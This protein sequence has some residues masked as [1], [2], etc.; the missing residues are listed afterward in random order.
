MKISRN[1]LMEMIRKSV[2]K[3][4]NERDLGTSVGLKRFD[5][6]LDTYNNIKKLLN[7]KASDWDFLHMTDWG[8]VFNNLRDTQRFMLWD[9]GTNEEIKAKCKEFDKNVHEIPYPDMLIASNSSFADKTESIKKSLM[10]AYRVY[11]D[12]IDYLVS[13]HESGELK[14]QDIDAD[15]A[16]FDNRKKKMIDA[17]KLDAYDGM[18]HR[19]LKNGF[20]RDVNYPDPLKRYDIVANP[21]DEDNQL[22]HDYL[23]GNY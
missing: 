6:I 3:V 19:Q 10:C 23:T 1:K 17:S 8:K 11:N 2:Q 4:L 9:C 15:W 14:Q 20:G 18:V 21:N 22:Y 13:K 5:A 12:F 7:S 16:E